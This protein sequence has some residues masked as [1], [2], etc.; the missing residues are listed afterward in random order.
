MP[1]EPICAYIDEVRITL[2]LKNLVSNALRYSKLVIAWPQFAE[3]RH[4]VSKC[5]KALRII[6]GCKCSA[7][8]LSDG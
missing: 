7:Y 1:A 3:F 4:F 2:L 8:I 6:A 5:N